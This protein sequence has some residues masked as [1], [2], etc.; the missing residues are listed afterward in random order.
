MVAIAAMLAKGTCR[1]LMLLRYLNRL[2]AGIQPSIKLLL[3]NGMYV[4]HHMRVARTTKLS[5]LPTHRPGSI[6]LQ[7]YVMGTP[8]HQINF[9]T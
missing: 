1:L 3:A 7:T 6:R 4:Q 9:A 2:L 5:A 8:R